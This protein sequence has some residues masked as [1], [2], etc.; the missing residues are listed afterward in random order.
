MDGASSSICVLTQN[1][2]M[3]HHSVLRCLVLLAVLLSH[4]T[5]ALQ[6]IGGRVTVVQGGTAI[7]PCELIDS[8]DDLTQITWQRRTRENPQNKNFITIQSGNIPLFVNGHDDRFKYIGN[9][10]NKN[11]TL[12][13]SSVALKDEGIYTCIFT[14]FPSGNQ[15]TEIPLNLLVPPSTSVKDN[16]P[17]L[18]T[19]EVLFATCTAAGSRP[20]AEVRWLT[21]TLA[22]KVRTTTNSTQY[23]NGTTTTVN[24]LFGVPTRELNG[25]LVQCVIS[26]DSLSEKETLPF[27]LQVHFSPAEVN[28]RAI[29]ED[30]FDCVSEGNPDPK[31]IWRRAG[32]PLPQSAVK[33]EGAK[34]QL[35]SLTSD[36]NGLYQ[37]EASNA[38]GR[39][40]A[41]LYVHVISGSCFAG[42]ALFSL[43][44]SLNVSGA[45]G[46]Y[47]YKSGCFQKYL[48]FW[49]GKRHLSNPAPVV[50]SN[51]KTHEKHK[52][53]ELL[54][55]M[56]TKDSTKET[57]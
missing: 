1:Y 42:W 50:S 39:K 14:L 5:D 4:N 21:G 28:I 56:E 54:T 26:G 53:E 36:L 49:H 32:Q 18:G 8:S 7:L 22:G 13:L 11:G 57:P 45:A 37:C 43:L 17:T 48:T 40:H 38:Y 12:Q 16:L 10:K 2:L 51:G 33:V 15:K 55:Y 29:S 9:F 23:D 52:E 34:L 46:W 24:S 27:T 35:L 47:F 20:P 44:L 3:L 31:F 41:Q 30:S 25:H 6:V 19:E